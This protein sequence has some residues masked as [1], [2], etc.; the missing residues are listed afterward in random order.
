MK[1]ITMK[2]SFRIRS[3]FKIKRRVLVR[4]K[5]KVS[6]TYLNLKTVRFIVKNTIKVFRYKPWYLSAGIAVGD[7]VHACTGYNVKVAE[8]DIDY[9]AR[10]KIVHNI[11]I[12]DN[13]GNDHSLSSCCSE[14]KTK[15]QIED[16]VINSYNYHLISDWKDSPMMDNLKSLKEKLDNNIPICDDNGLK[17]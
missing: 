16:D 2:C 7:M 14:K 10:R 8:L 6:V 12:I 5:K 11:Y 13:D 4:F 9:D 1:T 15:K 3:P 17:V